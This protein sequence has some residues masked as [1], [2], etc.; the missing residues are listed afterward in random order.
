MQATVKVSE[1]DLY[2][3][4]I[5]ATKRVLLMENSIWFQ[6]KTNSV[7]TNVYYKSVVL[8]SFYFLWYK[9][10]SPSIN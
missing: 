3:K 1:S 7:V 10:Q 4:E 6:T 2:M 8:P 5:Y 9:P